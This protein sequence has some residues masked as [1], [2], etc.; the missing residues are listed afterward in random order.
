M[1]FALYLQT[2]RPIPDSDMPFGGD[3]SLVDKMV[4][5][6]LSK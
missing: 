1:F 4:G 6:C 5:E 3:F 2:V